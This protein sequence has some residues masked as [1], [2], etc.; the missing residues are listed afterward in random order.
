MVENIFP[1]AEKLLIFV[2]NDY[3]IK[4]YFGKIVGCFFL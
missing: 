4:G 1:G 2:E 3:K